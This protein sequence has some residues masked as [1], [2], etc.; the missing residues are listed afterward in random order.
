M[1][2]V[3]DTLVEVVE[4][5]D[6][7]VLVVLVVDLVVERVVLVVDLVVERVVLVVDLV[8]LAVLARLFPNCK[9]SRFSITDL[10]TTLTLLHFTGSRSFRFST[11]FFHAATVSSFEKASKAMDSL[12][13][14]ILKILRC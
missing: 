7:V 11:S 9:L 6:R 1:L 12:V 2:E 5:V 13:R 4:V 3:V 10:L 8:A 14:F